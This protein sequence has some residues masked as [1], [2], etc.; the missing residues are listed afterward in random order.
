MFL[1]NVF[2]YMPKI[3]HTTIVVDINIIVFIISKIG[4]KT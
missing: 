2:G 1:P 4:K 3:S